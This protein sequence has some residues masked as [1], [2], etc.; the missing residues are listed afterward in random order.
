MKP[1]L[2]PAD[3]M[4]DNP[5]AERHVY[6]IYH[7]GS[8]PVATRIVRSKE[9][10]RLKDLK[11]R[12]SILLSTVCIFKRNEKGLAAMKWWTIYKRD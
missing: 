4:R 5:F 7:D 8:H 11:I 6:K 9:N 1:Y 12:L 10:D 2:I 3:Y